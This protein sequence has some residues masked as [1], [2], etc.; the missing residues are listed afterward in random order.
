MVSAL[1][2]FGLRC[3]EGAWF[4]RLTM[5]GGGE[6]TLALGGA[7]PPTIPPH[8][9]RGLRTLDSRRCGNDDVS[10]LNLFGLRCVEGAWFDRLTMSGGG[11]R[12]VG[13]GRSDASHHTTP[14]RALPA[15]PGFPPVRE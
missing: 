6:R 2:L 14:P 4:D 13:F 9:V 8:R 7:T 5:S 12:I 15:H 3:V 10:A 11:E 1:N